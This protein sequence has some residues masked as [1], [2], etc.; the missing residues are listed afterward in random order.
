M[1]VSVEEWFVEALAVDEDAPEDEDALTDMDNVKEGVNAEDGGDGG[2]VVVGELETEDEGD[3]EESV[4]V[5]VEDEDPDPHGDPI[6]TR[7]QL[8]LRQ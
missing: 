8:Q 5:T 3:G 7:G 2:T 1:W 6:N 4:E